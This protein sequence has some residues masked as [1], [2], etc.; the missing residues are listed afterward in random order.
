MAK[1]NNPI[2][3]NN[4]TLSDLL[5]EVNLVLK[6]GYLN[7]SLTTFKYKSLNKVPID[8]GCS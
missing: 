7:F 4:T 1:A 5:T 2:V 6:I 3:L 8:S